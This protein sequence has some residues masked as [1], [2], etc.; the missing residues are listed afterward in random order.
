MTADSPEAD[1][2]FLLQCG[3]AIHLW[4]MWSSLVRCDSIGSEW[5]SC[6]LQELDQTLFRSL[7]PLSLLSNCNRLALGLSK[8][9]HNLADVRSKFK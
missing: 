8:Q 1:H 5:E 4:L 7:E 2:A 3:G 6:W 9:T